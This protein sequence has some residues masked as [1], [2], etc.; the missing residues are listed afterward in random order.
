MTNLVCPNCGAMN[1][2]TE[3]FCALCGTPLWK[4]HAIY[5]NGCGRC[6]KKLE[7]PNPEFNHYCQDCIK[8]CTGCG[9]LLSIFAFAYSAP[10]F[11]EW[12]LG[13]PLGSDLKE[14]YPPSST[15]Q[16]EC[17]RC[18]PNAANA[19]VPAKA[20]SRPRAVTAE[21]REELRLG[22]IEDDD[23]L[24]LDHDFRV[25]EDRLTGLQPD[26]QVTEEWFS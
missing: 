13:L 15:C 18:N 21:E 1:V 19:R 16:D 22:L 23:P 3:I 20:S 6:H 26:D 12:K 17:M 4:E 10:R 24:S 5:N 25:A 8:I 7:E 9:R 14:I 11:A 2:T